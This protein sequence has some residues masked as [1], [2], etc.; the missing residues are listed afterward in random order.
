MPPMQGARRRHRTFTGCWKCR[1]RKVKRSTQADPFSVT[2]HVRGVSIVDAS[3][4]NALATILRSYGWNKT[5]QSLFKPMGAVFC[6]AV[7][8]HCVPVMVLFVDVPELTWAGFET[9]SSELLDLLILSCDDNPCHTQAYIHRERSSWTPKCHNPFSVFS[10]RPEILTPLRSSLNPTLLQE[11]KPPPQGLDSITGPLQDERFLFH[12]YVTHVAFIM[13]PY[14]HPYNPWQCYWATAALQLAL[15]GQKV[16][17]R[18]IL[19]HSAFNIAHLLGNDAKMANIALRYYNAALSH[20][21]HDLVHSKTDSS[22][23]LASIMSLMFAE[24]YR[25]HSTDWKHH[26]RGARTLLWS[27]G[28]AYPCILSDLARSSLESLGVIEIIAG[29]SKWLNRS[30]FE[31]NRQSPD[32]GNPDPLAMLSTPDFIFTIG[33]PRCVLECISKITHFSQAPLGDISRTTSNELIHEVL[34]CLNSVQSNNSFIPNNPPEAKHQAKAFISATYIYCYRTLL[35]VPPHAIQQHVHATLG[36]VSAF[37]AN[38][39]GNFS[40]W[41]AFIA[42]AEAYTQEDLATA[43]EW[44]NW[45]TSLSFMKYGED[46]R[47][48]ANKVV[49]ILERLSWIGNRSCMSL[50]LIVYLYD[51]LY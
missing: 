13:L 30:D 36:H 23:M 39:T 45:A 35:D 19:A 4:S 28:E 33:A 18:A 14:E 17:Y 27:Y 25:G 47:Y 6:A 49:W 46:A 15:S 50:N 3:A 51:A 34:S 42:A 1:S 40:A 10:S 29:S 21:T 26:L 41:P 32:A 7:Y 11:L 48:S 38:S 8:P 22:A 31:A 16:L 2:R 12:H 5:N 20:L 9:L 24:A 44:V 43:Q 37:L